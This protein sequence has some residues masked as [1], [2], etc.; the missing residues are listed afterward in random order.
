MPT[1]VGAAR[2]QQVID[3]FLSGV[4]RRYQPSGFIADQVLPRVGVTK[5]SGQYP[6]FDE[7]FWFGQFGGDNKIKD[8]QPAKEVD[9]SWSV[10]TFL[11]EEFALKISLSDLER[12]QAENELRLETSKVEFLQSQQALA[13]EIRVAAAL[14]TISNGGQLNNSMTS[15]PA[16]NWDTSTAIETDLQTGAQAI[17]DRTGLTPNV[18]ILPWKLAYAVALNSTFSAKLRYDAA[19]EPRA[20]I[21]LGSAVLP[22]HIHGMR[23]I[24]PKGAIKN[25]A[26][27]G[28]TKS[29]SEVWG[30]EAR[31]LYV[32]P[33]G[34]GWG[35][36]S[37]GY[38]LTHTP[39]TVTRWRQN[40]PDVEYIRVTERQ[41]EKICAPEA[42]YVLRDL[43]S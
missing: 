13:R 35:V 41:D 15:T 40:D 43:L 25:T 14:D 6:T 3:P 10:D 12:D 24:I 33:N 31:L 2:S 20:F 4:A 18:L 29:N 30:D 23:V 5:L 26:K 36:P 17:Y 32:D 22:T 21:D 28:A 42:G 34:G 16:T 7:S 37:V 11:A 9:F 38:Q 8:R 1:T 19:G 39:P 27:E